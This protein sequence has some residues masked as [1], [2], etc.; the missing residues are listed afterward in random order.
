MTKHK[1]LMSIVAIAAVAVATF[2]WPPL[3]ADP[4]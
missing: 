3:V 1:A 4:R 2:T